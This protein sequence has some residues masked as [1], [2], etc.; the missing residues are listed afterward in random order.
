M[1]GVFKAYDVRG[2]YPDTVDEALAERIGG[3]FATLLDE[4]GARGPVVVSRDM[5]PHSVPLLAA[6]VDGLRATGRDVVDV[7]L[8]TTPMSYFAVGHLGAAGGVQVTAS[9]N[10]ARYN[11]FK[12]S[13]EQARPVS[14]DDGIP[15]IEQLATGS[16]A[17]SPASRRG[18]L[19]QRPIFDAYAEHLL[20]PA[21][22]IDVAAIAAARLRVAVD[23]ANGM[24]ALYAPLLERVGIELLPLYFELDGTFPNH[25]ANPLKL[26]NLRDVRAAVTE[27]SAHLGVAFDGDADRAAFVDEQARPIG[28]D[29]ATALIGGAKLQRGNRAVER[30]S[31]AVV[32]DVRSSRAVPEY[33]RE[34]GG[35]PVQ[36][37]VGHSFIKATL[38]RLD[39]VFGG[40]LAGHYYFPETYF[41]D[42]SMLA[43]LEVLQLLARHGKPTSALVAPLRRYAKSEEINFEVED[44]DGAMRELV[45]RYAAGRLDRIDGIRIDFPD[46]WFNVRPSNTEPLLRLVLEASTPEL[47]EEKQDELVTLLGEPV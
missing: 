23:V 15:R 2:I 6:L 19:D 9:H 16:E 12:F 26:E 25:E 45:E 27:S 20:G 8:A 7:G 30:G 38:R 4:H 42:S 40:E 18:S 3:A 32:Y 46:W 28:S 43:V 41:A 36:E 22:G 17:P 35:E 47:L 31:K 11:G 10:P 29:L 13:L 39:G 5:R 33:I 1:A 24:G 37:R 44:K 34:C 14:G 21:C